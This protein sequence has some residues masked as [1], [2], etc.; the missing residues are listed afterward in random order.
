MSAVIIVADSVRADMLGRPGGPAHTPCFDRLAAGG[1]LF[2]TVISAAP[3]TVPSIAAMLAGV[4]PHRLGLVKWEQP[5][6]RGRSTLFDLAAAAGAEV[7]SF[8]FDTAH[9]FRN[10][11]AASVRGSSQD[12]PAMLGWLRE[13]RGRE[14]VAFIHYWWTHVP[15]VAKPMTVPTWKKVSDALLEAMRR[16]A[17]ARDKAAALYRLAVERFSEAFLPELLDA[18][19]LDA[20]WLFVTADHGESF[21]ARAETA[22]LRDVFDLHGN[23]LYREVLEVPLLVRPPGGVDGRRVG[24]LARTV[25][26]FPTA[27]DLLGFGPVPPDLDGISLAPCVTNGVS[28]PASEA[29]S[30]MN[31][32]FVDLPELPESPEDVWCGYALTTPTRKLILDTRTSSRRAFDLARDPGETI[33]VAATGTGELA[34]LFERL[35]RER[36][37]AVVGEV[38][39]GDAAKI[40]ERLRRLGYLE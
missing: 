24:G 32:D 20:T 36:G 11:E 34:P 40:R 8:V 31:R 4:Y 13:R 2:D 15:Y 3:W 19:D 21:G 10:V 27:A 22:A 16:S 18:V 37:R 14:F 30:V 28:A 6:P 23:T 17:S 38:L 29:I 39:P 35:E 33:D 25:D 1:V 9:L 7:G 26:L 5:W 12:V